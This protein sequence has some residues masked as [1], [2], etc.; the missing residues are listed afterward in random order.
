MF[1]RAYFG[2]AFW[3][4]RYWGAGGVSVPPPPAV[5][6][7]NAI[8][9]VSPRWPGHVRFRATTPTARPLLSVNFKR[10]LRSGAVLTSVAVTIEVHEK[11]AVSDPSPSAHIFMLAYLQPDNITASQW[12]SGGIAGADYI[13]TFHATC[14]VGE[15]EP[16]QVI[17]PV[18][19]HL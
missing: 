2:G 12:F 9:T 5:A 8:Y 4:A 18:R 11:S 17:L 16:M 15:I 6:T 1:G 14:S 19:S 13:L 7:P 10:L 3:G